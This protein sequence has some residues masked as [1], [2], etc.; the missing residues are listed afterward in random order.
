MDRP[1]YVVHIT[2]RGC[3]IYGEFVIMLFNQDRFMLYKYCFYFVLM[4]VE[5]VYILVILFCKLQ[6]RQRAVEKARTK[7]EEKKH[8]GSLSYAGKLASCNS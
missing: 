5:N 4:F 6:A 8:V 2:K 7:K 1:T 3:T